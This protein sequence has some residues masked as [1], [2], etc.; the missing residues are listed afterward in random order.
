MDSAFSKIIPTQ[1]YIL[2]SE[3]DAAPQA[4]RTSVLSS[5]PKPEDPTRTP[6]LRSNGEVEPRTWIRPTFLL[7]HS[8]T[9]SAGVLSIA[10]RIWA[11]FTMHKR[12]I[13]GDAGGACA[14]AITQRL[15][16]KFQRCSLNAPRFI[17]HGAVAS[18]PIL[19]ILQRLG[20][21]FGPHQLLCHYHEWKLSCIAD[22]IGII[23]EQCEHVTV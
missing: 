22:T 16:A 13:S 17:V 1:Y 10:T 23:Y 19:R 11:N 20:H 8:F 2:A 3:V 21:C 15:G 12:G 14:S 4:G 18:S 6:E 9:A 7:Q 5:M